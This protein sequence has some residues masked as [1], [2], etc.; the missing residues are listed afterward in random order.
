MGNTTVIERIRFVEMDTKGN[1]LG[2]SIGFTV[3]D[4]YGSFFEHTLYNE[5]GEDLTKMPEDD[6]ELLS[7]VMKYVGTHV[8][9]EG[10]LEPN[11]HSGL[12]I[13]RNFYDEDEWVK[14]L[15]AIVT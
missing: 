15:E 11:Y 4:E 8:E 12:M 6:A 13:G 5:K 2:S 3:A 1:S 7:L 9:T 10:I 14:M